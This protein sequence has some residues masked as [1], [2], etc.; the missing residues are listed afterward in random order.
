MTEI[1]GHPTM[2]L[3]AYLLGALSGDEERRVT[4]HLATCD[5]CGA[6]LL[7][8]MDV[9]P[10]L[11]RLDATAARGA[12][13]PPAGAA[14]PSAAAGDSPVAAPAVREA[15]VIPM[16]PSRRARPLAAAVAAIVAAAAAIVLPVA[17]SQSGGGNVPLPSPP[18]AAGPPSQTFNL[19][20]VT[21]TLPYTGPDT[22]TVTM[23]PASY[24]SSVD[25][26]CRSQAAGGGAWEPT[27][28][29]EEMTYALWVV[30]LDGSAVQVSSWPTVHG[31][32]IITGAVNFGM[33]DFAVLQLR[34]GNGRVLAVATA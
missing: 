22:I 29:D 20:A 23:A 16:R 30:R 3:A 4:E 25:V 31:D 8:L 7:E 12:V 14:R 9:L 34:D 11:A 17:I 21:R 6:H 10:A 24:G 18:L 26:R 1:A 19:A 2:D 28:A 13:P 27:P 33:Q 32:R 15:A 5:A